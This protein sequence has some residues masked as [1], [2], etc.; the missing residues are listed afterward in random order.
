MKGDHHISIHNADC[1]YCAFMPGC[2]NYSYSMVNLMCWTSENLFPSPSKKVKTGIITTENVSN[3][4]LWKVTQWGIPDKPAMKYLQEERPCVFIFQRA[5]WLCRKPHSWYF[6][7][8]LAIYKFKLASR[9][10]SA[11]TFQ[12]IAVVP[13]RAVSHSFL[14]KV[15]PLHSI[16]LRQQTDKGPE[17]WS[18]RDIPILI[19]SKLLSC[20]FCLW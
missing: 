4:N 20:P 12:E 14:L 10:H 17:K 18:L 2:T 16:L 6:F 15:K 19:T 9:L 8:T 7:Y 13:Q 11:H 1:C 5:L 3:R